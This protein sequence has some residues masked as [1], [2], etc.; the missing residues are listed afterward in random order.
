MKNMHLLINPPKKVSVFWA[1]Q[2]ESMIKGLN[3]PVGRKHE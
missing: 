1:E 3:M 2:N